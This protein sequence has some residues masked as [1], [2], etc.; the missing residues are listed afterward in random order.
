MDNKEK[1]DKNY[2]I[3][4]IL[5]NAV[6][7]L[8]LVGAVALIPVFLNFGGIAAAALLAGIFATDFV[9]GQ[10]ARRM[11]TSTFFGMFLDAASDKVIGII[12]LLTLL[13][14]SKMA[15]APILMETSILGVNLLKYKDK[16]NVHSFF[17]GK[18]KTF[19]LSLG[20]IAAFATSGLVDLGVIKSADKLKV[21]WPIMLGMVP[22][23][24]ACL[25]AYI[26]DYLKQKKEDS[27]E[28][29]NIEVEHDGIDEVAE[30]DYQKKKLMQLEQERADLE[31][32]K[33]FWED[34]VRTSGK[35]AILD[36]ELFEEKKNDADFS[37]DVKLYFAAEKAY[38]KELKLAK[39][40]K[41]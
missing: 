23:E 10:M 33:A 18:L 31:A 4:L 41:D 16:Q 6:T 8:R 30:S 37:T 22:F 39:K 20:V 21:L 9:D 36:H 14:V 5:T 1:K 3:K 24:A 34:Y 2:T 19:A 28:V 38:K 29:D 12:S 35:S 13:F 15:L 11:G 7:M 17:V 40:K 32:R 27:S 26:K 25:G